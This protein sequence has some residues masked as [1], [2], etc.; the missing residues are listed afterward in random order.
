MRAE[1]YQVSPRQRE[2]RVRYCAGEHV[3]ALRETLGVAHGSLQ[4]S[5]HLTP[6]SPLTLTRLGAQQ[7]HANRN[8]WRTNLW[9]HRTA[10]RALEAGFAA[11]FERCD[12][13]LGHRRN[14]SG[15]FRYGTSAA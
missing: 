4:G 7:R 8:L 6:R 10:A 9:R 12:A 14:H 3:R 13:P 11:A 15:H 5:R 1:V 2:D